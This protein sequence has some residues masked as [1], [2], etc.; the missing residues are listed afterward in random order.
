M[1]FR[2]KYETSPKQARNQPESIQKFTQMWNHP[3]PLEPTH[4]IADR[5][6]G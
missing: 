1:I 2:Q 6:L 3:N 5:Q 4:E